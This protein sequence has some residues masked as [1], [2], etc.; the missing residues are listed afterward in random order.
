MK[1]A[2]VTGAS[3]GIGLAIST[4]LMKMGYLVYGLARDFSKTDIEEGNFIKIVCDITNTSQLIKTVKDIKE[5]EKDIFILVNNAGV[6]FFGPHEQ[7]N[8][9]QIEM[10]VVTNLQAPL[11]ITQLLLREIKR[12]KGFI[13]NISSIT[14]KKSSTHGCAYGATKAGLSHFGTSLFDEVRKTGAKVVTIH[15][16][17]TQTSFYDHLDFEQGDDPDCFI[18]PEC[19]ADTVELILS[20]REG[21]VVSELTIR[22][23]K[24]MIKR[25]K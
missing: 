1:T 23:Q 11:I 22:P 6:G 7:L 20:Q 4:R 8:P 15:P 13:I 21:T 19:V 9:K 10:M 3:S 25:K 2:I 14:A 24:H 17:I 16:D 12:T 5:R 18:T